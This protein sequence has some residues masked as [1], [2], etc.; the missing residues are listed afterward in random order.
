MIALIDTLAYAV[1]LVAVAFMIG[2]PLLV[3]GLI[4]WLLWRAITGGA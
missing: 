2:V 3:L 4:G 1:A